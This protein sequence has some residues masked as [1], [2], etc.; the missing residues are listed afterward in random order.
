MNRKQTRVL[1]Y[2]TA[3]ALILALCGCGGPFLK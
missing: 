2:A 1:Y 3:G